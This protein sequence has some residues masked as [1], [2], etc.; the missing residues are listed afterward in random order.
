MRVVVQLGGLVLARTR[1]DHEQNT[2]VDARDEQLL[3]RPINL[4]THAGLK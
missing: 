4:D 3:V 2:V 1:D